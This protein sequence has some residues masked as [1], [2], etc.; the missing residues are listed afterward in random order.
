MT[1][2]EAKKH[3]IVNAAVMKR[4]CWPDK[5]VRFNSVRA[6]LCEWKGDERPML[7]IP[8]PTDKVAEDWVEA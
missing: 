5:K 2:T 8:T 4:S 3:M 1:F 6:T 7:Y